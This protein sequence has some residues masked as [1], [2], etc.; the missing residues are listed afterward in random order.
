MNFKTPYTYEY[1]EAIHAEAKDTI[2]SKTVPDMAYTVRELLEKFTSNSIPN[3][4]HEALEGDQSY[5]DAYTY[6][7]DLTDIQINREKQFQLKQELKKQN[8]LV[9]KNKQAAISA[10]LEAERKELEALRALTKTD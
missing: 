10:E 5:D 8:K 2:G 1:D 7:I 3:I 4:H 9:E 6:D